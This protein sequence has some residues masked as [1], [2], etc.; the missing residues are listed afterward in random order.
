MT[1][2]FDADGLMP[3]GVCLSW[4]ANLMA[5]VVLANAAIALSYLMITVVL[6]GAAI[7]PKP[8]VPRWL[9]WSFA[10][11]IFCCGVSHIVDD[12][13]V[14]FPIYRI[15]AAVLAATAAVSLLAA[16]LPL[17]LWMTREAVRW[18]D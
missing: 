9:Y 8:A 2:W 16:I 4:N 5:V 12:L 3:H 17:S 1:G 10:L 7:A 18:R 13:T 6:V 15:Q 11:F 14:W